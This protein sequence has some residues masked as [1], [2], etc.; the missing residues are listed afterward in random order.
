MILEQQL[1]SILDRLVS[2]WWYVGKDAQGHD[3]WQSWDPVAGGDLLEMLTG[4]EY[5]L[6]LSVGGT[7]T[8][9]DGVN[10]FSYTLQSGWNTIVWS[11]SG[12]EL[13]STYIL[14]MVVNGNGTT[15]PVAG[16]TR[17]ERDRVVPIS[18]V[19]G[20]GWQ[21]ATWFGNVADLNASSTTVTMDGDKT[22]TAVFTQTELTEGFWDKYKWFVIFGGAG[23]LGLALL[24]VMSGGDR[25]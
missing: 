3:V 21:F 7:L 5:Q 23:A 4:Q 8:Y 15:N 22:V 1:A 13:P 9:S 6:N 12:N 2:I 18:A 10:T 20:T 24:L 14:T 25:N 11:P 16:I 19:A 17:F